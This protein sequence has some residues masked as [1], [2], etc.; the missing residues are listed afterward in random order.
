MIKFMI[1][2]DDDAAKTLIRTILKK[3]FA[4]TIL[5]AENGETALSILKTEIPD[6]ILLDISMPVMD[7]SELLSLLRSNPLFKTVPV[8]IITAMGDKE[9]VGSLLSKGICDYL[10]KPIDVPET[11]KR[12]NKI[13]AK[14][15]AQKDA[16]YVTKY[17]NLDHGLPGLLLVENDNKAKEQ[18]HKLLGD[19]FIIYDAKNGT[20]AL[21]AF[22]KLS[23]RYIVVSD[24]IG[25]LDKKII[26]QRIGETATEK[27]VSIFLIA[28]DTKVVSLKIFTF[29]GIIVKLEKPEEFRDEVIKKVLGEEITIIS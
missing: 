16:A 25:L 19:R 3:N 29:D 1:I 26:T 11:V 8:L 12:I 5:E 10:L 20:D 18:F 27:E 7:G 17:N 4:C 21:S 15:L 14:M 28:T 23:P 6:I 9:L 22:E 13:I 2:E 24:K